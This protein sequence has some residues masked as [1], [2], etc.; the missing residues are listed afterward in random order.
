MPTIEHLGRRIGFEKSGSGPP[1]VLLPPG[2]SPAAAWRRVAQRLAPDFCCLAVNPSGYGDTEPFAGPQAITMDDEAAAVSAIIAHESSSQ[3]VHLV[4]HSYGGAI[5]LQMTLH[6]PQRF[7]TLTLIEAA[8][9]PL[10]AEAGENELATQVEQVNRTYIADVE[11]GRYETALET[12]IDYYNG[13]PGAW[14]AMAA[15]ARQRFLGIAETVAA[16][17]AAN[18]GAS[19]TLADCAALQVPT[20]VVRGAKT[21][22]VHGRLAELLAQRIPGARL[23][24]VAEAGHMLTL[25]HPDVAA[26]LIAEQAR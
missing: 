26:R 22:A 10:L 12:Y 8:P 16:G 2:A 20:L 15:E 7:A 21:D 11:A 19:L 25:S 1:L 6:R 13:T 14:A 17:L 24:T 5:A 4:G 18:H 23:E 9:Y 3:A